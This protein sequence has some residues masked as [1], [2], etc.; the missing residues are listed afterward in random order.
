MSVD[1]FF[2]KQYGLITRTQADLVG[3]TD[4]QID[5]R[6]A[7]GRWLTE[8]RSVYRLAAVPMT[9]EAAL[10]AAVLTTKGVASHRCAAALWGLEPFFGP[11]IE[12]SVPHGM[13]VR[14]D[15]VIAHQSRQWK[16]RARC[17][18]RRIP[19]TGIERTLLDCG[20]VVSFKTL[21]RLS[22]SA[23]RQRKTSWRKLLRCLCEHSA[24][25]RNGCGTL[26]LLLNSRVLDGTVTLSD[27]SLL[28][29]HL[30]EDHHLPVPERE[31]RIVDDEG[32]L[33][34]QADLAW[35][36]LKKAWELDGLAFHF[37]RDDVERDRR[38]RNRAKSHGWNIQEVLWSMYVDEPDE[39]VAMARQF[40]LG[41]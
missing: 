23:I 16:Q 8:Q 15:G 38:K 35:P 4:R 28:V 26:R 37:G 10:L 31:Y 14:L 20:A 25:G 17:I 24:Q 12:I 13:R 41:F 40:L 36:D 2:R 33:I 1:E 5:H 6:L 7:T 27:F 34:L 30:L 19:A 3:L 18:R 29:A 22:E 11:G 9:W 39:L 21:E 32:H